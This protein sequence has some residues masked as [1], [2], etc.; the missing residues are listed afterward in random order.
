MTD[1]SKKEAWLRRCSQLE[2]LGVDV[3]APQVPTGDSRHPQVQAILAEYKV[4]IG[5]IVPVPPGWE[6][7]PPLGAIK[8]LA[9]LAAW[10]NDQW[11]STRATEMGGEKY[12]ADALEQADRAVRN[13]FRLLEWL[14]VDER[15]VRPLPAEALAAAKQQLDDLERWVRQKVKDGWTPRQAD[16]LQG[17]VVSLTKTGQRRMR[18][19]FPDENEVN[20]HVHKYLSQNPRAGIRAVVESVGFSVGT[21][22]KTEAWKLEMKRREAAKKP[23]KKDHRPLTPEMLACIGKEDNMDEVDAR[24]DAED[25]ALRRIL[26]EADE[27]Q[28][29]EFHSMDPQQKR[30]LIEKA[31]ED[32]A[33]RMTDNRD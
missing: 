29:A 6:G 4:A 28:R 16:H 22:Q 31:K 9:D 7:H 1:E 11:N 26:E 27:Q 18:A 20:L 10:L 23:P 17:E 12:K 32:Y 5:E 15:P 8:T 3:Y 14:G 2:T 33:A 24:I 19:E 30:R 25:A 13:G 21:V